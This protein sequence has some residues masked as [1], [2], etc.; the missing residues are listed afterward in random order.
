MRPIRPRFN[1]WQKGLTITG[2][3]A[4]TFLFMLPA[5]SLAHSLVAPWWPEQFGL[6]FFLLLFLMILLLGGMRGLAMIERRK[7]LW[8]RIYTHFW[9]VVA[10]NLLFSAA[11]ICLIGLGETAV[12]VWRSGEALA[13]GDERMLYGVLG[14][15]AVFTA[16]FILAAAGLVMSRLL[17]IINER[18]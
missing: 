14:Y 17:P 3:V 7:A 12:S 9:V 1:V 10:V 6:L 11:V 5:Y 4:G 15:T 2:I 16:V 13:L 8:N 18:F